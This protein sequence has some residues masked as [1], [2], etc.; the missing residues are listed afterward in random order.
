MFFSSTVRVVL[1]M[2]DMVGSLMLST[3]FFQASGSVRGKGRLAKECGSGDGSIGEQIGRLLAV[4]SGSLIIGGLPAVLLGSLT[5]R[6]IKKFD[7]QGCPEWK[8][9]LRV[10]HTQ[11]VMMWVVSLLYL[12]F[13]LFFISIF[14]ANVPSEDQASWIISGAISLVLDML[15]IPLANALL[16]P[17]LCIFCLAILSLMKKVKKDELIEKEHEEMLEH[18]QNLVLPMVYV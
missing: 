16:V 1:F 14:I 17:L 13:C 3:V 7:Y 10:W 8:R 5:T 9:Q 2:V 15:I 18:N 11:D 12:G 6:T 4:G